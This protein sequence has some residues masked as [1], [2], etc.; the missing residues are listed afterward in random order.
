MFP[1]MNLGLVFNLVN[2]AEDD[3]D[4][5]TDYSNNLFH[6]GLPGFKK[7]NSKSCAVQGSFF[8]GTNSW[9]KFNHY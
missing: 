8:N 7:Q 3:N 6:W 4:S 9:T 2:R 5:K 1:T